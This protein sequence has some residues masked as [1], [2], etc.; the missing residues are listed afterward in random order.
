M[1]VRPLSTS[2]NGALPSWTQMTPQNGFPVADN[3]TNV[4]G[5]GTYTTSVDLPVSWR[6]GADGAYLNLGVAVDTVQITVNGRTV[7]GIDQNDR[8]EIDLGRYLRPGPN[9]LKVQVETPLRNAV[10]VAPAAPATG[11]VFNS[12]EPIGAVQGGSPEANMGLIGPVTLTPYGQAT[13]R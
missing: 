10:A 4:A 6:R 2:T 8:N 1:T 13:V 7:M 5:I 11:Q 9:T 12:A 3:L